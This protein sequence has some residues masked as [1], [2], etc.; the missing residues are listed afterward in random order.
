MLWDHLIYAYMIENTRIIEIFRRVVHEFLHGEKLGAP[1]VETQQWLRTTEQ[2]FYR[3]PAVF[4][5]VGPQRIR[6]D[7]DA[8]GARL[9]AH[10]RHGP[11]SRRPPTT[12]RI[13]S[14]RA[15]AANKEFVSTFEE[16]LREVWIGIINAGNSSGTKSTDDAKLADLMKKLQDMLL[17]RRCNGNLSREEFTCVSMMSWFH[18]TVESD[19]A[20][21]IDLRAQAT[22][23]EQRLFKIAQ[24]VGV[25]AHGLAASYFDIADSDLRILL[26]IETGFFTPVPAA[27]VGLYTPGDAARAVHA[28]DHHALVDHHRP[29]HEGRQ[30][31]AGRAPRRPGWR[32]RR[33]NASAEAGRRVRAVR[34][35]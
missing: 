9:S 32:C 15:E 7:S 5:A 3:D 1:S 26:L 22:S 13:P 14:L 4:R 16:L 18:L 33:P 29:R 8:S 25:P 35:H 17:A 20:V 31:R 24:L 11:E 28:D 12:S 2:L 27:V 34:L 6:P 23:A 30:D 21:V 10:V 19:T